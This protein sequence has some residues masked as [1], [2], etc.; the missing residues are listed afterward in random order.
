[1]STLLWQLARFLKAGIK[2]YLKLLMPFLLKKKTS[3]FWKSELITMRI[4]SARRNVSGVKQCPNI[5]QKKITR[6]MLG[7]VTQ[8]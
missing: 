7:T 6:P 2:R 1:M 4:T 5:S 3:K 8:I